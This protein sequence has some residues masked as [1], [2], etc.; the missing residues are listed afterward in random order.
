MIHRVV[1][2]MS[3]RHFS[4]R[5]DSYTYSD[6]SDVFARLM[7]RQKYAYIVTPNVDHVAFIDK[8]DT[9][10]FGMHIADIYEQADIS[11]CDSRVLALLIR[12]LGHKPPPVVTGSDMTAWLFN[13][14]LTSEHK[15]AIIGMSDI[16]PLRL[17][18]PS[19]NFVHHNPAMGFIRKPEEF[20]KAAEFLKAAGKL[21][22]V[23]L[24]VGSPQGEMLANYLKRTDSATGVALSIGASLNFLVGTEKRA[25]EVFRRLSIE[26]LWR[27]VTN[28]RRLTKRYLHDFV[29]IS[30]LFVKEVG[31]QK[32]V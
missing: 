14:Y 17:K 22:F 15:V 29:A 9:D 26:W 2:S 7:Q 28:P 12:L 25:P 30:R 11:V 19:Y 27:W 4:V 23:L 24:A 13:H 20:E 16:T 5:F 31:S 18:Y 6:L 21:D 10:V 1:C 32:K 8:N 3:A